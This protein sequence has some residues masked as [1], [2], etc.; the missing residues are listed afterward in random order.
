[1]AIFCWGELA[2]TAN[3]TTTIAEYI[4][5]SVLKHN[6]SPQAHGLDSYAI[7]NHRTDDVLDHGDETVI[8]TK[9]RPE[10]IYNEKIKF[11]ARAYKATV[12]DDGN[13]D[14]DNIQDAI[15]YVNG[16]GGGAIFVKNGTYKQT[17]NIVLYSDI[18]LEGED[19]DNTI[20]DFNETEY[21]IHIS[22]ST[23]VYKRNIHILRFKIQN[24]WYYER[25]AIYMRYVEDSSIL[26]CYFLDNFNSS[27]GEGI[28]IYGYN[29]DRIKVEGNRSDGAGSFGSFFGDQMY[30]G[31]NYII[32]TDSDAITR[33]G[34]RSMIIN[35]YIINSGGSGIFT[36][37]QDVES[38]IVGNAIIEPGSYGIYIFQGDQ[39]QVTDNHIDGNGVTTLGI[40]L[41]D[42]DGNIIKGNVIKDFSDNGIHLYNKCKRNVITANQ[43]RNSGDYAVSINHATCINNLIT[44]NV[45]YN[46]GIAAIRDISTGTID[47]NN[48]KT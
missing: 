18:T 30:V 35:N 5:A 42:A 20:I 8:H 48:I 21:H 4:Q 14:F 39:I 32:N 27:E 15:D 44:S 11:I 23:T 26:G 6:V 3:D 28:D 40:R 47:S 36:I 37:A 46:S 31:R 12:S 33:I 24:C 1:M 29:A 7:Y 17:A 38:R 13:G 41:Y 9:I 25:G 2:K 16:I 10:N 19:D 34:S 22:G 43:V 45:L